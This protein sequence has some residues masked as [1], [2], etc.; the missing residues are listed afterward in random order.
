[1]TVLFSREQSRSRHWENK[2]IAPADV[3]KRTAEFLRR[4]PGG[5]VVKPEAYEAWYDAPRGRWIGALEYSL[6]R[7]LLRPAPASSVLDIGC[8]TGHFTRL[9]AQE[10]TG[11]VVGV[12]PNEGCLSYANAHSGNKELYV[13]GR[14]EAL[15]FPD[16]S[17]DFTVSVT[18]LCFVSDQQQALRELVR[19]TRRRFVLG[20]LNR[21]SLLYLDKG[22]KGGAGGYKGAH[23][24][25]PL[26]VRALLRSA[27]VDNAVLRSA[28]VLP[29]GTTFARVVETNWPQTILL[30]GFLAVR[31]DLPGALR[32]QL[33]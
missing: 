18:A 13:A 22:R 17:F 8:G 1:M 16:Q 25:T 6:L 28:I 3:L 24:H 21:Y 33:S 15:P 10:T 7:S 19:V 32:G 9:F 4:A 5:P 26:E 23:W 29:Q 20:L 2:P 27:A 12:D 30:G 14:A 11:L 31:G